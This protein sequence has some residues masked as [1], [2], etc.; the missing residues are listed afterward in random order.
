M[1]APRRFEHPHADQHGSG[2]DAWRPSSGYLVTALVLAAVSVIYW[3]LSPLA[4]DENAAQAISAMSYVT[5]ASAAPHKAASVGPIQATV[6][7]LQVVAMAPD[8]R[9]TQEGDSDPTPDLSSYIASYI[10]R[11]EIPTMKQVI[12]RLN[13]AGVDTG[14]GAF[15]PPGTRPP[16]V[17]LAVPEEFELPEG[18]VRHHQATDDGQRIE[19]ILMFAPDRVFYDA[20]HQPIAIPKDRVVT[21]ELAPN[22]L[23]IRYV[24]VPAPLDAGRTGL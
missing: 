13:E 22:G 16:K 15:N 10:A 18:Y 17:G 24:V 20:N 11:G 4:P 23:P 2:G 6:P 21:P 8:T 3:L 14:L 7:T 5:S 12:E 9:P 1:A 19:A